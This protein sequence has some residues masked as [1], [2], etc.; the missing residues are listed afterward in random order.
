MKKIFVSLSLLSIGCGGAAWAQPAQYSVDSKDI[1]SGF[2]IKKV[3]LKRYAQPN[4][5]VSDLAY[6]PVTALPK[7]ATTDNPENVTITMGM[8]RKQPFAVVRF[9]AYSRNE[10]GQL[11]QISSFTLDVTE[12]APAQE[13][14]SAATAAKGTA[15]SSVLASGAWYKIAVPSRGVYKI[16]YNFLQ[17]KLG[18][19]GV[20]SSTNI[21]LYGN[22]GQ[23][24]SEDN[25]VARPDDLVENAIVMND[26]GDGSFNGNDYFLF[27][28]NGPMGWDW[29][30]TAQKYTHRKNLYADSSYYFISLDQGTGTRVNT[31]AA[32]P[33]ANYTVRDF[34]DYAVHEEDLFNPGKFGKRWLGEKFGTLIPTGSAG[35]FSFYV[36]N[37]VGNI[38]AIVQL[39]DRS[40]VNGAM[41]RTT[42][43]GVGVNAGPFSRVSLADDDTPY[44]IQKVNFNAPSTGTTATFNINYSPSS[45]DGTGF[46]DYLELNYRRSLT[47]ANGLLTFRDRNSVGTGRIARYE[48]EGANSN[49]QVWDITD[50]L[51]PVMMAGSLSGTTYSFTQDAASLH[52]FVAFDGSAFGTPAFSG[53]IANQ[54]IHGHAAV[55]LIIVTHAKFLSAARKLAD[56]HTQRDKM[57]VLLVTNEQVYNE[58]SSGGQDISAI[59][60]MARMF[61]LRA[62]SNEAEMPK[63]ILLFGDAS[64]DYKNRIPGNTNFVPTFESEESIAIGSSYVVDEFYTMLDD[65]ENI[66]DAKIA[67]TLDIG[68]GRLPVGTEEEADA[69]T[70]K[71][72]AYTS[73]ASLGPWRLNNTYLGDNED[74]A[75]PHLMQA[76]YMESIIK[77]KTNNLYNS[78]K[79]YLDN[80]PFVSTPSGERCPE[81]NNAINNTIFKG[82]F[83]INF[84]GHGS[85][86]TLT[87]E[88]VLTAADFGL[89]KN[90]NKL[91]FMIT[92]TCDFSRYD[93]PETPS[94]GE[95]L[96]TKA[97]GGAIA[98]LTTTALVYA[99]INREINADFLTAQFDVHNQNKWYSFGEAYR[100]GKNAAYINVLNPFVL[101]NYRA[102]TLLGDPAL[103]PAFPEHFIH[104]DS[105][106]EMTQNVR[107]DS[108]KALGSYTI[109]GAVTDANGITLND[110]NGRAYVTIFDKP[111]QMDITSKSLEIQ[112]RQLKFK[113]QDNI[114]YKGIATVENGQFSLAFIAPKDLNYDLGQGR[115]S[116]YAENGVT[117]AAGLD[118]SITI[119]DF[120]DNPVSD[121]LGPVVKAYMNDTLFRDGGITG[122]STALH[123]RLFDDIGINVSGNSVGHDMIAILDDNIGSPYILNDYYQ[124]DANTYKSG[125]LTFPVTGLADGR[126]TF[127]VRAWDVNN[128]SGQGKVNFV[129]EN[130]RVVAIRNLM[131]Y[132][133]PFRD[134]THFIFEHNHPNE[135]YKVQLGIYSMDGR[136]VR[137]IE[138]SFTPSGS[139]SNEITWDGTD[140]TG[141]KLP[142]GVYPYKLILS[143]ANGV[144]GMAHQKAVLIR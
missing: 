117:D 41:F 29:D 9:P 27:Y 33:A 36:G 124:T 13:S 49:I 128:N 86:Y 126:H 8:E 85:I 54:D 88:R 105:I 66:E 42:L 10:A 89:W 78:T 116:Y 97:D 14:L 125:S 30:A 112:P 123:V 87:H 94:A 135:T 82:T 92:A 121:D 1:H 67:N 70:A 119:G 102:F 98:M 47:M 74:G 15:V 68:V 75:G 25:K 71:I 48:I 120:S 34:N 131:N 52:E 31:Q 11:Q 79:I 77:T 113:M 4:V 129:V 39:A 122:S 141:A 60:D 57:R 127:T 144:Q 100:R 22:G 93:R 18:I 136:T 143:T 65:N 59:R 50:P 55:D 134:V 44:Y 138:Q 6:N 99:D 16:D 110:F 130:G 53:K 115:I 12:P 62:G 114:I 137:T 17:S 37:V 91:P 32:T 26:G 132:P 107:T 72:I 69:M 7:D 61:Y 73:P 64:Y 20:I 63:N 21:K 38:N 118:T 90:I 142:S 2:I 80:L 45:S 43:N 111:R 23:M 3:D 56:Y 139:N 46:L 83:L 95:K 106:M 19:S 103:Q 133:N 51:R 81:G 35:S 84:T 140:N 40:T 109:N 58:F 28:A 5:K 96:I 101:M 76:E 24:L 104:T 108:L